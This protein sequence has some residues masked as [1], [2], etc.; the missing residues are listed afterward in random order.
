MSNKTINISSY[1]G[2]YSVIFTSDFAK[3]IEKLDHEK[4]FIIIDKRVS[5]LY[6][7]Q[8]K[9]ILAKFP[10]L[11]VE[12][13]EENK[14]LD[15][16]TTYA[17]ALVEKKLRR[18]M[19]LL[20]IGGGITQD[21]TCFLSS[22]LFR[23]ID[24]KFIPTTLLAQADSCIG[25]KSSINVG[26]VKNLMGTFTPP[27]VIFLD[28]NFLKTLDH[29]DILSGIGEMIKVHVIDGFESMTSI[30]NCYEEIL[31]DQ[32]TMTKFIHASLL[33][34]KKLIEIDEFDK[35]PRNVMNYGHTFGHAIEAATNF[36]V[37]HGVAVTFGM[38]MANS[39]AF[40]EAL[41]PEAIQT[42]YN[43]VM[44]KNQIDC[45]GI[46]FNFKK[47]IS[48]ISKD[49]KNVGG[50]ITLILPTGEKAEIQKLRFEN[51]EKFQNF[52]LEYF[53]AKGFECS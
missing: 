4:T 42:S 34:K 46:K 30:K 9:D 3:E 47:F 26:D 11:E 7:G 5:K 25:S 28:T 19:T 24:W 51:N 37:P 39:F 33:M 32:A 36:G 20:A 40:L 16:F 31:N 21:I 8:L 29:N 12:A 35:G 18:D 38:E 10:Y 17:E 41:I 53:Q 13:N 1:K 52:C 6:E 44:K 2:E 43:E 15:K 22:T 50:K 49:K 48:A 45:T 23:G 14:K 27:R